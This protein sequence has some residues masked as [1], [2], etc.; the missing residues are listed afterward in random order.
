MLQDGASNCP[1]HHLTWEGMAEAKP[2]GSG[3]INAWRLPVLLRELGHSSVILT[4]G[5]GKYICPSLAPSPRTAPPWLMAAWL[6]A[7]L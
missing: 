6:A 7:P 4:V 1:D 2:I 3:G 5:G